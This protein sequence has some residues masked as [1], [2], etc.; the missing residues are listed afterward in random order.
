MEEKLSIVISF[1]AGAMMAKNWSRIKKYLPFNKVELIFGAEKEEDAKRIKNRIKNEKKSKTTLVLRKKVKHKRLARRKQLIKE[2]RP[3]KEGGPLKKKKVGVPDLPPAAT[4]PARRVEHLFLRPKV[5]P[6]AKAISEAMPVPDYKIIELPKPK[7]LPKPASPEESKLVP[8]PPK[9]PLE[10][11]KTVGVAKEAVPK[12]APDELKPRS[13]FWNQ[14]IK[15][16]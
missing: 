6:V 16:I 12:A 15:K 7:E 13:T 10:P 8:E 4:K 11:E 2:R 9:E 1:F 3:K 5:Q 14:L